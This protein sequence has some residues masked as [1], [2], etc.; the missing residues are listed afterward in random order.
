MNDTVK[1]LIEFNIKRLE[2]N[3]AKTKRDFY[4]YTKEKR[5]AKKHALNQLEVLNKFKKELE[6]LKNFMEVSNEK[7]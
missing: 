5:D 7:K 3:V 4:I 1:D 2:A 6:D